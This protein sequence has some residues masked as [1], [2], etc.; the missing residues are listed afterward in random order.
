MSKYSIITNVI[1]NCLCVITGVFKRLK[2]PG[3]VAGSNYQ[4]VGC[5]LPFLLQETCPTFSYSGKETDC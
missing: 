3:H 1:G 2:N 5:P 4:F